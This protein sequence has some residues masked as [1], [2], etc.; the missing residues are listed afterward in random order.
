MHYQSMSKAHAKALQKLRGLQRV[1][2]FPLKQDT[3]E[4]LPLRNT[5]RFHLSASAAVMTPRGGV[6]GQATALFGHC[7]D[8]CTDPLASAPDQ[9]G[10][11]R[12]AARM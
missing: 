1:Q 11:T 6:D 10:Q 12:D 3:T 4:V 9:G 8:Q 2:A 5:L 7:T